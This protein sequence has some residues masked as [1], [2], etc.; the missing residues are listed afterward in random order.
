M[1]QQADPDAKVTIGKA[2]RQFQLVRS[3]HELRAEKWVPFTLAPVY[4]HAR[5]PFDIIKRFCADTGVEVD[6]HYV[7]FDF[8]II[9][10]PPPYNAKLFLMND[11]AYNEFCNYMDFV[12][13][14]DRE[15]G[16]FTKIRR[17]GAPILDPFMRVTGQQPIPG[18]IDVW[19]VSS[20]GGILT[21]KSHIEVLPYPIF[22]RGE[23]EELER[24]EFLRRLPQP[25]TGPTSIIMSWQPPEPHVVM[26]GRN[27]LNLL[28]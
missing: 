18:F 6:M 5:V 10:E 27:R 4:V 1:R 17:L 28:K 21:P 22:R 9:N 23:A 14:L 8:Q 24:A 11:G 20:M 12:E 3:L 26:L 19:T 7:D 2:S 15:A 25:T 16:M 13:L